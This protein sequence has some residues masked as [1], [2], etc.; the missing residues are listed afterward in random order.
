M[1]QAFKLLDSSEVQDYFS[2]IKKLG[3]T[4]SDFELKE[5][6]FPTSGG[7]IY[8][9][10]GSVTITRKSTGI[11]RTYPA[12]HGSS[13]PASFHDDLTKGIFGQREDRKSSLSSFL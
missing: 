10:K 2:A 1:A 6:Q 11:E 5:K 8:V 4:Q 3:F 7:P 13:W 12:G 9:I